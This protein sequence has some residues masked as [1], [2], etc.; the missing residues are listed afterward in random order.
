LKTNEKQIL[1]FA[2]DDT[3]GGFFGSLLSRAASLPE[4]KPGFS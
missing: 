1:R 4:V 2:Q 3:M